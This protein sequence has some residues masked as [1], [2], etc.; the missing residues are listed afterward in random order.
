M[1]ASLNISARKS[2][3]VHK[4]H[5]MQQLMRER[6]VGIMAFQETHMTEDLTSQLDNLFGQNL[7][8]IYSP[9]LEN[10]NTRGVAFM[11]NRSL[12]K[13]D[14]VEMETLILGRMMLIL[15]PWKDRSRLVALNIYAPNKPREM[16]AFWITIGDKL[17]EMR[18]TRPDIMLRDLNLVEDALDRIPS[19]QGDAQAM[20]L[21][22]E[23]RNDLDMTNRW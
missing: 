7:R 3:I 10:T 22:R 1:V 12:I 19:S 5:H 15:A 14:K 18:P 6:W 23:V 17:R 11:I 9:D 21:L 8:L 16:R 2:G 20:E 4:R 13:A